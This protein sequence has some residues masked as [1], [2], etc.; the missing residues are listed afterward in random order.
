M[1]RLLFI[2]VVHKSGINMEKSIVITNRQ[3]FIL[4]VTKSGIN[5]DNIIVMMDQ[6]SF[7]PMV[8]NSGIKMINTIVMVDRLLFMVVYTLGINMGHRSC[9]LMIR[10]IKLALTNVIR[11]TLRC[12]ISH[13]VF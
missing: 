6:Q 2:V 5:M 10:I 11:S 12:P 9:N 4:M 8:R 7:M 3:L 1:D 13:C